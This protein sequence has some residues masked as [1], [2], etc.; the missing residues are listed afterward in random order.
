MP[1]KE[2]KHIWTPFFLTVLASHTILTLEAF[3]FFT[4]LSKKLSYYVNWQKKD[5]AF[6]LI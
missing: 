2:F 4:A 5:N 3:N 1:L 6:A